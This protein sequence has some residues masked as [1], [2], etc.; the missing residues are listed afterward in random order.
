MKRLKTIARVVKYFTSAQLFNRVADQMEVIKVL[1]PF[2]SAGFINRRTYLIYIFSYLSRSFSVDEKRRILL[3]NYSFLRQSFDQKKLQKLFCDGITCFR[4]IDGNDI[5]EVVLSSNDFFEFEGSSALS[6]KLNNVAVFDLAFTFAPGKIFG[7]EDETVIYI[8]GLQG[9]K[10][11]FDSVYKITKHFKENA[12]AIILMKVLEAIAAYFKINKLFGIS[13]DN[14]LSFGGKS[15]YQ[16]FYEKYDE[17]WKNTGGIYQQGDYLIP[18]PMPQKD[19]LL[20]K[21]KYRN[22]TLKK[23]EVL[24]EIY[25]NSYELMSGILCNDVLLIR[26]AV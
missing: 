14:Q 5:Y 25:W 16:Y 3:H 21:Q 19:I 2:V 4:E 26:Q 23:R 8:S 10:N 24:K 17:F 6:L 22:R 9:A 12:P 15:D 7:V 20:V 18:L 1:S 11:E 13:V